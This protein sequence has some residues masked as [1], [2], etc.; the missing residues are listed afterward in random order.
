MLG[1]FN[2]E[3]D[4]TK[5]N[6]FSV[7][8]K[9]MI[10]LFIGNMFQQLYNMVDTI[11]VGRY[12]GQNALAAVGSTGTIMF[13]I[14]GF[15]TG[16]TTGFTVLTSQSFGAGD[17]A[18]VK[19]SVANGII[20]S[21]IIVIIMTIFSEAAMKPLLR[22]MNTPADIFYDA[23]SY[24]SVIC[25]GMFACVFYNLFSSYL[26]AVGNS[27]IPLYFLILS[28]GLNI[29]LDLYLII[30]CNMGVAGAALATV[31]SQGVSAV[32]CLAYIYWKVPLIKPERSD[33]KINL[34]DSRAQLVIGFPMAI[35]FAITASGTMIM[36]SAINLFGSSAVAAFTAAS[37]LQNL[38]TQGNPAIGQAMA[39]YCGQN[40]G[41]GD[42]DRLKKGVKSAIISICIYA[43]IAAGLCVLLLWNCFGIFFSG[44]A[45]I[46]AMMPWAEKYIYLCALFYIPLGIIFILR[47][48]IQG[49]GYS[50]LPMM[51]GLVEMGSRLVVA[52][53][54]VKMMSYTLTCFCDPAAWICTAVY[55]L[56]CYYFVMKDIRRKIEERNNR[57]TEIRPEDR[58]IL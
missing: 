9:F 28:A 6:P 45:D 46:A 58:S 39:T 56:V 3:V 37:K 55:L 22:I 38:I 30:V 49:C 51:G 41:K 4:M 36:Q 57:G 20:L 17:R 34:Q 54:A 11:I 8:L 53:I 47:N 42:Y 12:V 31:I 27:K 24:I 50:F 35:Q 10:P 25:Y 5:G 23:Y 19:R 21:V 13:L 26:R 40:Y 1:G 7:I 18:R 29:V 2:M 14:F 33:W 32:C 48:A 43:V 16:L 52:V 44:E 15:A